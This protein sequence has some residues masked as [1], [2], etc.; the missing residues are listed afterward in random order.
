MIAMQISFQTPSEFYKIANGIRF[1]TFPDTQRN[2]AI[3]YMRV[4]VVC[5]VTI[6]MVWAYVFHADWFGE[7]RAHA[8]VGRVL[9]PRPLA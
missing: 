4:S 2:Y 9:R 3:R 7:V 6:S 8:C 1:D 5:A